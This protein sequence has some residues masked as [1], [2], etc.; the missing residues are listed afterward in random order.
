MY[1]DRKDDVKRQLEREKEQ[2]EKAKMEAEDKKED[3]DID[4]D[5]FVKFKPT[6]KIKPKKKE[7]RA[8]INGNKYKYCGKIKDFKILG[9]MS[10]KSVVK[11]MDFNSWKAMFN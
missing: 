6:E 11:K 2:E 5:L 1:I 9:Q 3:A 10:K 4:D 8:A 7:K